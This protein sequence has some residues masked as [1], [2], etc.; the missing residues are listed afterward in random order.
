[1]VIAG[2]IVALW[3]AAALRAES[4][5]VFVAGYYVHDDPLA[6]KTVQDFG[7]R[8][9]WTITTNFAI[10]DRTG[11]LRGEHDA[12][13]MALARQ[14]GARVHFRVS[15]LTNWE[16]NRSVAHAIL[17][18]PPA[19]ARAITDLI[20]TADTYGYDGVNVDLER[21]PPSDR[22]ALTAFTKDLA[23]AV[24]ARGKLLSIA[25]P[26]KTAD[27]PTDPSSGAFDVAALGSI[28]DRMILMAYDEHWDSGP[29]GPV[30]S[31]PW[32]EAVVRYAVSQVSV[33][34]LLLGVA[35]YGY[36]W[37]ARGTGEGISMREAVRRGAQAGAAIQWDERAS[38]P[39]YRI[40]ARTIYFEN[41]RS[42]MHKLA[43]QA[44]AG[45]AGIAPWRLGHEVPEVWDAISRAQ[46]GQ[47]P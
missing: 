2:L 32:V 7:I 5:R 20:G 10:S 8:L 24:H 42:L 16:F 4:S 12:K 6:L 25:V 47:A 37:P 11:A 45:L 29:P 9:A 19:R 17:V 14:R 23:E 33:A 22:A 3:P 35:F 39:F 30:A 28:V 18:D 13:I 41:E 15:N 26:G 27:D 36:D 21:V 38:V 34:K 31:L 44:R 1:V 46:I 43:V 40:G